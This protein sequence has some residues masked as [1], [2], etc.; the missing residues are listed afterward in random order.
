MHKYIASPW[1][2]FNIMKLFRQTTKIPK[3]TTHAR[4]TLTQNYYQIPHLQVVVVVVVGVG[5]GWWWW[6]LVGGG[7]GGGW[8][9]VGVGL[10]CWW[11]WFFFNLCG[12]Y[13]AKWTMQSKIE[14]WQ[15]RR[16]EHCG[17]LHQNCGCWPNSVQHDAFPP[18]QSTWA[19]L[20]LRLRENIWIVG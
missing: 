10:G 6:V 18:T 3:T 9:G 2:I 5:G 12:S 11:G 15:T 17:K 8:W 13:E 7:V 1:P 20:A 19:V 16:C 4:Y 14:P